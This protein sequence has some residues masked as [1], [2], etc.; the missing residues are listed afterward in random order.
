[1]Y[2][3]LDCDGTFREPE[4]YVETHGLDAPPYEEYDAC[5]FCGGAYVKAHEC[6]ECG[7]WIIGEYIKTANGRRICQNCYTTYEIGEEN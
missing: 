4:H 1:M 2:I 7:R 5:P 6:D 3:C